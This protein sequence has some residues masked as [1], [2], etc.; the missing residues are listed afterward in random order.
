[1]EIGTS[2]QTRFINKLLDEDTKLEIDLIVKEAASYEYEKPTSNN[3]FSDSLSEEERMTIRS[4]TGYNF[5]RINAILRN[6]W[7]YDEHGARTPELEER[8]KVD[9]VMMD[10]IFKKNPNTKNAFIAYRGTDL[11]EFK[12][13]GINSLE[14]LINLK[15]KL[16]YESAYT[17][18]SISKESSYFNKEIFNKIKN[19]EVKYIIPPNSNDGIYLGNRDLSYS[20]N[21]EEYILNKATLSKVIDVKVNGETAEITAILIPKKIWEKNNNKE[22]NNVK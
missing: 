4:Y 19:I 11:D 2:I 20:T 21:Q 6:N 3:E 5:K 17:S 14:D 10:K 7:N 15:G 18:T 13:Y 9:I 8:Y 16:L 12:K 22:K 1:M